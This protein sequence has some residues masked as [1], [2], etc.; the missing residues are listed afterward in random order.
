MEVL[1]I[2]ANQGGRL[3]QSNQKQLYRRAAFQ[4]VKG[5]DMAHISADTMNIHS[6]DRG[7]LRNLSEPHPVWNVPIPCEAEALVLDMAGSG[8]RNTH[9]LRTSFVSCRLAILF[10][11]VCTFTNSVLNSSPRL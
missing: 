7:R 11:L 6:W 2:Q 3:S 10:F 8:P 1:W 5:E 4:T 9:L